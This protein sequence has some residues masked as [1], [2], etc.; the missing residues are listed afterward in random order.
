MTHVFSWLLPYRYGA[1]AESARRDFER[2]V[3][4]WGRGGRGTV[5]SKLFG[6]THRSS[7][8]RIECNVAMTG[9]SI[10]QS[11]MDDWSRILLFGVSFLTMKQDLIE[12]GAVEV[13]WKR[14]EV[15]R[16]FVIDTVAFLPGLYYSL[17]E[18]KNTAGERRE[19]EG[20]VDKI[21]YCYEMKW[22]IISGGFNSSVKV[23]FSMDISRPVCPRRLPTAYRKIFLIYRIN[24]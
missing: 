9:F 1:H 17:F 18:W 10:G 21:C 11:L 8:L 19:Q 7:Q 20:N 2:A 23:S 13:E 3:V 22:L 5:E 24:H 16:Y 12:S 14:W 4:D 6:R 15:S